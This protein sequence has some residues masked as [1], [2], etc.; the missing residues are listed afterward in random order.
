M[1]YHKKMLALRLKLLK[2]GIP[3][4]GARLY[5]SPEIEEAFLGEVLLLE[6]MT[7]FGFKIIFEKEPG[8]WDL[9]DGKC[10]T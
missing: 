8:A 10:F 4:I 6:D 1:N 9:E 7:K 2:L 5:I 3:Q